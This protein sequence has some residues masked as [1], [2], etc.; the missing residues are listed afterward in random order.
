MSTL[1]I[2]SLCTKSK[3]S[4][5]YRYLLPDLVPW[6]TLGGSNY[7]CLERISMVLKMFEPLRFDLFSTVICS[8]PLIQERLLLISG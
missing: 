3:I 8:L 1:N 2:Q 4:L 7:P 5:N 6:L